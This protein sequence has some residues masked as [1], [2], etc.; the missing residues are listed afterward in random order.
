MN[1]EAVRLKSINWISQLDDEMILKKIDSFRI[2]H[3]KSW[4][5]LS[6]EDQEAI[7]EGLDQLNEGNSIS[8][9]EVRKEIESILNQEEIL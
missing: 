2:V 3:T 8:Y 4:G 9:S 7:E 5:D 1:T 6:Y